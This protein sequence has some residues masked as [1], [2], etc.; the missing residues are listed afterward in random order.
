MDLSQFDQDTIQKFQQAKQAGVPDAVNYQKAAQ[1]QATKQAQPQQPQQPQGSGNKVVDT[2][3]NFLPLIGGVGGS[4]IPGLGTIAGGALGAGAGTLLKQ[5]IEGQDFNPGEVA[6]EAALS[7]AGGVAGK[8]LGF[9]LGKALPGFGTFAGDVGENLAVRAFRPSPT[10]LTRFATETGEDFGKFLT[11]RGISSLD[12][13]ATKAEGLQGAFD[14]VVL[15]KNLKVD[16][17][18]VLTGFKN[19]IDRLNTSILPADRQKAEALNKIASNFIDQHGAGPISADE[20]TALRRQI[21][22]GIKDFGLDETVKGPL[23]ITR[24]VLQNSLRDAADTAGLTVNGQSLKDSGQELSKLYKALELGQRQSNLGRGSLPVG[25]TKLLGGIGGMGVG[26]L[27]GAVAGVGATEILNNPS[28]IAM[29]SKGAT[30]T[31]NIVDNLPQ[32][33]AQGADNLTRAG[34][35]AGAGF[36]SVG[37]ADAS[38]PDIGS[39]GGF[40]NPNIAA[41]AEGDPREAALRKVLATIMFSKAK[42]VSDIKAAYEFL[43]PS[44]SQKPL[45]AAQQQLQTNAQSGLSAVGTLEG[46]LSKDPLAPVKANLPIVGGRSPYATAAREVTDVISRLRSGA[47]LTEDEVKFYQTQLPQQ[48]DSPE[49]I[50]YK[51]NLFKNLFGK[52]ANGQ[53]PEQT[54]STFLAQ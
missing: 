40:A 18:N 45:S 26:G 8:G 17:N 47:A 53:I 23:N 36:G 25:L 19:E 34:I 13:V 39:T 21:D 49:T 30:K 15:N 11:N 28:I 52:Y 3:A 54:S 37:Q 51:L 35:A 24:D 1:Y 50:Q 42:S 33:T 32:M 31:G 2:I 48:F 16:P 4:F 5:V 12:D 43:S 41:G 46:I 44:N 38:S 20:L 29:L 7:G 9:L 10:Q 14:N 27:P 6:K 22:Q